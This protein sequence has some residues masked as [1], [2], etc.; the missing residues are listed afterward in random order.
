MKI[1]DII[2]DFIAITQDYCGF[3]YTANAYRKRRD[4][5]NFRT[6]FYILTFPFILATYLIIS[7]ATWKRHKPNCDCKDWLE[8]RR[9][10]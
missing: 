1:K 5:S 9:L 4:L 6:W 3:H 10:Q 2:Y 8:L 7:I